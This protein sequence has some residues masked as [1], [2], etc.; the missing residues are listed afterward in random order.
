MKYVAVGLVGLLVG[1]DD[2]VPKDPPV[3]SG[4][5]RWA[6]SFPSDTR[7][8]GA[9]V[10]IDSH[11]DVIAA[12]SV[13]K[14]SILTKRAASDGAELWTRNFGETSWIADVA[15]LPDDSIIVVGDYSGTV[16]FGGQTRTA[17][18]GSQFVVCYAPNGQL[19]WLQEVD[20]DARA[21]R[22]ATDARGNI[23]I[24]GGF[25]NGTIH[26]G[27]ASYTN[28][29]QSDTDTFVAAFDS[30]GTL[31]WGIVSQGESP[32]TMNGSGP[33]PGDIAVAPNGDILWTA[34]FSGPITVGSVDMVPDARIRTFVARYR[35]DG[36]FA[37]VDTIPLI[38][39]G[40]SHS[41]QLEVDGSGHIVTQ[42]IEYPVASTPFTAVHVLD[43]TAHELWARRIYT[44]DAR[45]PQL[46][47]LAASPG[48]DV[49]TSMW[50]DSPYAVD[51][52]ASMI[53]QLDAIAVGDHTFALS[54]VG[55][56][57]VGAPA[58]TS[59]R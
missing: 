54:R 43:A 22:I 32:G 26:F 7:D 27:D 44:D 55:T 23:Y 3:V 34:S 11:G 36:K 48:G 59:A 42:T 57:M 21:S 29:S 17:A 56:R 1:C 39:P 45:S 13:A 30:A 9:A 40:E 28:P 6:V 4:Q 41:A 38:A 8:G 24:L 20:W 16:D 15:R 47:T 18:N 33:A 52:P 46:R 50:V 53:G 14:S 51:D 5:A 2:P 10:V 35:P 19:S 12:G 25:T 58:Q 37:A 49:V 31:L